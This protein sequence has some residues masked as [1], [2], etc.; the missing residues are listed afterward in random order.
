MVSRAVTPA[1]ATV[2]DCRSNVHV[3][4]SGG[5]CT[6]MSS[7]RCLLDREQSMLKRLDDLQLMINLHRGFGRSS[8]QQLHS[9]GNGP[10]FDVRR[11]IIRRE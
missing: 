10:G 3:C 4:G 11:S 7:S 8:D 2:V 5:V 6:Q 1:S 9:S